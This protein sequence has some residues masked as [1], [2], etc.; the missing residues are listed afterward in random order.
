ML[1][2]NWFFNWWCFRT[3]LWKFVSSEQVKIVENLRKK[4]QPTLL[5]FCIYCSHFYHGENETIH[6]FLNPTNKLKTIVLRYQNEK[7]L[8]INIKVKICK[9]TCSDQS[10]RQT[11]IFLRICQKS[12]VPVKLIMKTCLFKYIEN[13]TTKN[14]KF[15]NNNSDIFFIFSSQ[16]IDCGYLLEPPHWGSSN[17]YRQSYVFEQK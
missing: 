4:N 14:W 1:F 2:F 9:F 12:R 11:T 3:T 6:L 5:I 13:F 17:E 8:I 16:N 7:V 15:S 10:T